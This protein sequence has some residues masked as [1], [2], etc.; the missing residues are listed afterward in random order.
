M[1]QSGDER[2]VAARI[3]GIVARS[4]ADSHPTREE[5]LLL[6]GLDAEGEA[7]RLVRRRAR[8]LAMEVTAGTGRVWSAVGLDS[9]PCPMNCAFCSFGEQWG[10]VREECTWTDEEVVRTARLKALLCAAIVLS[11]CPLLLGA[12]FF[13][14]VGALITASLGAGLFL[15]SRAGTP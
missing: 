6:L 15:L 2:D 8:V 12:D 14:V 3:E 5:I 7:A 9:R 4:L 11:L 1:A 10:L 13:S